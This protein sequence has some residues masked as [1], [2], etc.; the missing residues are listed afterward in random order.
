MSE[1]IIDK[2]NYNEKGWNDIKKP[3]IF[4]VTPDLKRKRFMLGED[5]SG[6]DNLDEQG[7]YPDCSPCGPCNPCTPSQW[8]LD[9]CYPDCNPCNPCNPCTPS[10][11]DL[12]DCYPDCNPC[13]PCSPCRPYG[14]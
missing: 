10:Q 13:T 3:L 8:D 4:C 5:S 2:K 7:C 9:D 1:N 11:W 12:G 14:R 6:N